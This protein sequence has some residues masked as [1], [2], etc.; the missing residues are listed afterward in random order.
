MS[1]IFGP[2]QLSECGC[3]RTYRHISIERSQRTI[4]GPR[5]VELGPAWVL[6]SHQSITVKVLLAD[7][8]KISKSARQTHGQN[9]EWMEKRW[10][11]RSKR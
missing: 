8:Q 3:L 4:E 5:F 11:Q 6:L 7:E 1:D 9:S 2:E 10:K